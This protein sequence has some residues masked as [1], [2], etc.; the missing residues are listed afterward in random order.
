[1]SG[2]APLSASERESSTSGAAATVFSLVE[3]D[4][5]AESE[6]LALEDGP[7][8][9]VV[10]DPVESFGPLAADDEPEA[11]ELDEPSE[12]VLSATATAGIEAIAMPTPR[13]TASAPTRPTYLQ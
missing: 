12:P 10:F 13:A 4:S 9:L 8:G 7:D 6:S 11:F 5:D 1:M 2:E 3:S